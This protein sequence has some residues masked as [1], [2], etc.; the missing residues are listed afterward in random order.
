MS[1]PTIRRAEEQDAALL[2][3]LLQQLDEQVAPRDATQA[4]AFLARCAR[5]PDYRVY[6]AEVDQQ[7]V[8]SASLIVLDNLAHGGAPLAVIENVV[9]DR[10]WRGR[11]IGRVIRHLLAAAREAGC[12][13]AMLSA[14]RHR[15]RA[16]AFYHQLGFE[17]HGYS[18]ALDPRAAA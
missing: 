8:A 14:A 3:E 9:V 2:A 18:L 6:L 7:A 10:A 11:S 13:K 5:Y 15:E 17:L 16:H 12:Y 1:S 4:A